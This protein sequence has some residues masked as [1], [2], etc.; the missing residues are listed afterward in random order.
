ME[1]TSMPRFYSMQVDPAA[2]EMQLARSWGW[3]MA[4]GA[5]N[6]VGGIMALCA[7][8]TATLAFLGLLT[9]GMILM[10]SINMCGVCYL[11]E[12][13]RVPAFLGGFFIALLGVLMASNV[14]ESL[15]V[16]TILVAVS[17]MLEGVIR[18]ILA[19]K[20]RDMPGWTSVLVSGISAI[21]LSFII[22][23]AFP[24]SSEYTLGILLGV[25]WV[26]WGVQRIVLGMVGRAK[27]NQ[28]LESAG[29]GGAEYVGAP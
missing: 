22:L 11:E 29:T 18:S 21:L 23:A 3:M 12:C 1:E 19:F 4:A 27:A 7:P 5:I 13:Y 20:N 6:L 24:M 16:I 2:L 15:M 26:T 25:N 17:Y 8:I 14:V 9:F 10:G 28:A